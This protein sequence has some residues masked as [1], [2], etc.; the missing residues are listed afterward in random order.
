MRSGTR[1][2]KI[3]VMITTAC[4]LLCDCVQQYVSP[5]RSPATGYLVVDGYISGNGPTRYS[6]S[7]TISLPG[8]S[9]IPAVTGA[10]LQVEGS[11]GSAFPLSE[12]GGGQYGIDSMPLSTAIK[13]RLRISIPGGGSYLSDYV[14]Y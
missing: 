4:V 13:Y 3:F 12:L 8:D 9:A 7:R 2:A 6:L 11:D 14:P 10:A 5:Y 1:T